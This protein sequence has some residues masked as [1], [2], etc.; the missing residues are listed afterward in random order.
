MLGIHFNPIKT[1][2]FIFGLAPFLYVFYATLT[3]T[4]GADP[5][6][7]ILLSFGEWTLRFLLITLSLSVLRRRLN[8]RSAIKYRR[9][10]GLFVMF[11]ASLHLISYYAFYLGFSFADLSTEIIERPYLIL[12][13]LAW[14]LLVPLTITSTKYA[15]RRL[16]KNW[17]KLHYSIY[18]IVI[19]AWVH[20]FWQVKSDINEAIAYGLIILILLGERVF[21]HWG[22]H[23]KRTNRGALKSS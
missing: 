5:Q 16:K 22:K 1:I 20:F 9:M 12:G 15:M 2:V 8:F 4:L 21:Y 10:L 3:Q 11:Y 23:Q 6:K 18:L 19:L 7:V 14:L 17:Q 13:F